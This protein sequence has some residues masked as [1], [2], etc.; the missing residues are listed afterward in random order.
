MVHVLLRLLWT[1]NDAYDVKNEKKVNKEKEKIARIKKRMIAKNTGKKW[2]EKD[3]IKK[4]Q[5]WTEKDY[6]KEGKNRNIK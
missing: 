3:K 2:E 5:S 4:D 6:V 1:A